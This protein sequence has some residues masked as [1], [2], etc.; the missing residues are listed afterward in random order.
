MNWLE[1]DN[2]AYLFIADLNAS[3]EIN[4]TIRAYIRYITHE[5]GLNPL[6]QPRE[7]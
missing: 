7:V 3:A 1:T 5:S 4:T 2:A 6:N